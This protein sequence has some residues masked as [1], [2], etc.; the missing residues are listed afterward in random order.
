MEI[1]RESKKGIIFIRAQ[2]ED[3]EE[4]RPRLCLCIVTSR[5]TS[6]S[7]SRR[8]NFYNRAL[9]HGRLRRDDRHSSDR[10]TG[11]S[12]SRPR[13]LFLSPP[14]MRPSNGR[15][16]YVVII[17]THV[18]PPRNAKSGGEKNKRRKQG[19]RAKHRFIGKS[20]HSFISLPQ[21]PACRVMIRR[22]YRKHTHKNISKQP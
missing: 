1:K 18:L 9:R 2:K 6:R 3:E 7:S 15:L 11:I 21:K 22:N 16:C 19:F 12:F 14:S 8:G 17:C 5:D 4:V 20:I 13:K 10:A